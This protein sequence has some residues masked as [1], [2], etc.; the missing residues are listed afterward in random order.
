M[1]KLLQVMMHIVDGSTLVNL[2]VI[3]DGRSVAFA[4]QDRRR[5]LESVFSLIHP[6]TNDL[7]L[8][9]K[10]QKAIFLSHSFVEF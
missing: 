1:Y 4:W 8:A 6:S 3:G 10:M 5:L 7:F 2:T 9:L